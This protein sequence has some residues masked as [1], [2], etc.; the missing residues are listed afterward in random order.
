MPVAG[1]LLTWGRASNGSISFY[2]CIP[3]CLVLALLSRSVV[4][5]MKSGSETTC[6]T[7]FLIVI[8]SPDRSV[9]WKELQGSD[10]LIP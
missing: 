2:L 10:N 9:D 7:D 6:Y 4:V 3:P 8:S 5:G 1:S